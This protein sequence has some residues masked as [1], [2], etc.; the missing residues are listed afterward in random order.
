MGPYLIGLYGYS[1]SGKDSVSTVLVDDFGYEQR[2]MASKIRE[3]LLN[4]DP[5]LTMNNGSIVRMKSLFKQCDEDWDIVKANC[6]ESVDWM[7][8][9]GQ[10]C[11]DVLGYG[12]WLDAVLPPHD[13]QDKIVISDVRQPNEYHAIKERGGSI[14]RVVRRGSEKRGMDGILDKYEF[15]ATIYNSGTVEDLRG[16]VQSTISSLY[17]IERVRG[18]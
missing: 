9:I 11:R 6:S 8:N 7:I 5:S 1:R 13:S 2:P 4:L 10:G 16:I 12:V 14:W 18:K 15:D 3:L 17:E